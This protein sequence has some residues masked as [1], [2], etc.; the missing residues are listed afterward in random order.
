[1][2]IVLVAYQQIGQLSGTI[3]RQ[4]ALVD[5]DIAGF[6]LIQNGVAKL[7]YVANLALAKHLGGR[8]IKKDFIVQIVQQR[9]KEEQY[10]LKQNDGLL[11]DI[12]R[13]GF[14][15]SAAA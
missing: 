8:D 2:V 14:S 9:R 3:F 6:I 7:R 11:V 1:M 4:I 10:T 13:N 15:I 5:G 12:E